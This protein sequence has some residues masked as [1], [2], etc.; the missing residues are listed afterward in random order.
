MAIT[1]LRT[2]RYELAC[3]H[4][5]LSLELQRCDGNSP[6]IQHT[7]A[8]IKLLEE[9]ERELVDIYNANPIVSGGA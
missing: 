8:R 4:A 9:Q 5:T 6:L 2:V 1:A 3:A 7:R